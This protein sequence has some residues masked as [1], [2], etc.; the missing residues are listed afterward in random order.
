[1]GECLAKSQMLEF[2]PI[3]AGDI[4]RLTPF[5][6]LRANKTCDSV[7]LD[8]FLWRDAYKVRYAISEG[9]AVQWLME[10]EGRVSTAMPLCRE[11]ELPYF[12]GQIV[13]YFNQEL[14][15]PLRIYLADAEAVEYLNLDPRRFKVTEMED[16][17]DYLYDGN[18]LRTLAGKKLHKKK[19]LV[20]AFM[21]EYEGRY[22]YRK[23]CCSDR[24]DVWDFLSFWRD[25]KGA[26]VDEAWELDYEVEGIHEILKNCSQLHVQMGGV[27]ID[28]KLE[29]F[30][31]GSYNPR[32]KMAVI[33]IEKANPTVKGLYQF[34]NQQFLIHE[35]P[36]AVLVNREDDVGIPGLR[37]A[38]LSYQ[39]V[40]YARKYQIEQKDF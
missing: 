35:F 34:I 18:A 22:E 9:K 19:N 21:R 20:N 28:G 13:E 26:D 37:Q 24:Q 32:E 25:Q 23:L 29:A 14:K 33:S 7:F 31:V 15:K 3:T 1:M 2:K 38:K 40:G 6:S 16:L 39:P 11:E 5:F 12:F 17:K 4:E 8:S 10:D 30:S 36:D 27:Y